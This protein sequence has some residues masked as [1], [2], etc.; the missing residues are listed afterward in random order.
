MKEKQRIKLFLISQIFSALGSSIVD[1]VLV[2]YITIK[3]GSGII[4]SLSL[5]VTFLP[6]I[7][8]ALMIKNKFGC[9][10]LKIMLMASDLCAALLSC[11]L[12]VVIYTRCDTYLLLMAVMALRTACT[13]IQ[14]PCQKVFIAEI[15][16]ED[17]LLKVN[18]YHSSINSICSL[19]AP[20]IGG[21]LAACVSI[22]GALLL[23]PIT[24]ISA[25]IVLIKI[26]YVRSYAGK[27]DNEK[28]IGVKFD[29][30]IGFIFN[31]YAVFIFFIVP[32][33]YLTPL[34]VTKLFPDDVLKLSYNEMFYSLGAILAS[35]L[36][37]HISKSNQFRKSLAGSSVL[38]GVAIILMSLNIK[39]FWIY[40]IFMMLSS[41]FI[42]IFQIK[43]VICL[44][45]ISLPENRGQ[46]FAKMEVYTNVILPA[47]MIVWGGISDFWGIEYALNL[48]GVGLLIVGGIAALSKR[49][50]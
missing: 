4:L 12:A 41:F 21:V 9:F 19:L 45:K 5:L 33:T 47:G 18:G 25:I 11:V 34:L 1:Y 26:K 28:V 38:T 42:N 14:G 36:I 27:N 20:A 17:L 6:K 13:G 2:W 7:L 43:A 49:K 8:S 10:N 15:T 40:L 35:I 37:P 50:K 31:S 29:K 48:S 44:Q 46:V 30:N 24:V 39:Y 3:S 16:P 22:S 32:L 23:D